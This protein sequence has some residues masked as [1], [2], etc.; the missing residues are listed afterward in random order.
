[1]K[2]LSSLWGEHP[3]LLYGLTAL[4]G[5]GL[6]FNPVFG[7]IGLTFIA[8]SLVLTKDFLRLLLVF[9]L[10]GALFFLAESSYQFPEIPKSGINGTAHFK[11][12]SLTSTRTYFGKRWVYRGMIE[13]FKSESLNAERIPCTISLADT[14]EIT[15]PPA[16]SCYSIQG[17]LKRPDSGSYAFNVGKHTPWYPIQETSSHAERRYEAKQGVINYI[18]KH[19]NNQAATFLAAIA[20]GEFDDK[21]MQFELGRFGLQH[22]MAISGFHF[23]IVAAIIGMLLRLVFRQVYAIIILICLL[24]TYF[25]FLGSTASIMRA[26]MTIVIAL[27]G[28]LWERKSSGLNSLGVALLLVLIVDPIQINSL[29]FQFSFT[30]TAAI[31]IFYPQVD[32]LLKTL[33]KKRY[34]GEMIRMNFSNQHGYCLLTFFRSAI[35]LSIAVNLVAVPITFYYFHQFPVWGLLYNLFFPF[36]VSIS[37]LLLLLGMIASLLFLPISTPIHL[38]NQQFTEFM[39]DFTYKL[40]PQFDITLY[41]SNFSANLSIFIVSLL[42]I[43]GLF[44]KINRS[45]Q[46]VLFY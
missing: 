17:R 37:M 9:P 30:S 26:W 31:L 28:Y 10:A 33:F 25:L 7:L 22:I 34:L 12:D 19:Y 29:G 20:T 44:V 35:A 27:S 23:A 18:K 40:P 5:V 24:S 15:H 41:S 6:A 3:A 4:F 46:D 21:E 45:K 13:Q 1:M 36:M 8:L 42:F 14:K 43:V 39:L 11:I 2:H 32:E 16:N 38:F